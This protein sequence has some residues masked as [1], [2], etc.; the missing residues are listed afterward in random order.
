MYKRVS[1]AK[2]ATCIGPVHTTCNC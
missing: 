1:I 2:I